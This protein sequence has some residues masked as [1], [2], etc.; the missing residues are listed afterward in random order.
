M[1]PLVPVERAE[2][3]A[4]NI[5]RDDG[6]IIRVDGMMRVTETIDVITLPDDIRENQAEIR[7]LKRWNWLLTAALAGHVAAQVTELIW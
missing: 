6:A 4:V 2:G 3:H 5:E 1:V 7:K